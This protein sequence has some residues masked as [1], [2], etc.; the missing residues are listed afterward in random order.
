M[1][2]ESPGFQCTWQTMRAATTTARSLASNG[3]DNKSMRVHG[4]TA[5][6][7]L[8][9]ASCTGVKSV[10][11]KRSLTLA[12]FRRGPEHVA[13]RERELVELLTPAEDLYSGQRHVRLMRGVRALRQSRAFIVDFKG[14][15]GSRLLMK[16]K[17]ALS[18]IERFRDPATDILALLDCKEGLQPKPQQR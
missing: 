18:L 1:M 7:I 2:Y 11:H 12:D 9:I 15:V 16:M 5:K 13:C 14:E 4:A 6:R 8:I 3:R 10:E 17:K